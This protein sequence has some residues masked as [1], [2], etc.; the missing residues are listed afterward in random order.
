M[1]SRWEK[2]GPE[3]GWDWYKITREL[4]AE[5]G[6]EPRCQDAQAR[7][8]FLVIFSGFCHHHGEFHGSSKGAL[9]SAPQDEAGSPIRD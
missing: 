9:P 6:F 5:L 1:F 2:R 7:T 4:V 3:R 8:I